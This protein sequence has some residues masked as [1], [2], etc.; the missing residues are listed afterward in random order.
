M[1]K[2]AAPI[3]FRVSGQRVSKP[4]GGSLRGGI[5]APA[6][7]LPGELKAGVRVGAR[8]A[9]GAE[10]KL[11][12]V[13][14]EDVVVLHIAGGPSLV[15]HPETARDLLL[16]QGRATRSGGVPGEVAVP[17]QLRWKGLEQ[18]AP[19]RTRGFLGDVLLSAVEV[20]TGL[21]KA[22]AA[23]WAA[24]ELGQRID[25]AVTPG[26][27]ALRP[28]A[29]GKLA[30][31]GAAV[32][33]AGKAPIL[34]LL[35][36]TFVDTLSTFGKLW[37]QH[38][39]RVRELFDH[40]GAASTRWTTRRWARARSPTRWR[41]PRSCPTAR[42]CTWPRIR[43]AG[44]WPRCWPAWPRGPSSRRTTS[45]SSPAP[46]TP[47]SAPIC[48]ASRSTSSAASRSSAWCAWPA[49]RAARCWP[50]AGWTPTCR[51]SSGRWSSAACRWRRRWWTSWPRWRAAAPTRRCCR[52]WRR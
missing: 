8:R 48:S 18:A 40:Y 45:P 35:H 27:Y 2:S 28:Q 51:C 19:T 22:P 44:W 3:V 16:G 52:G 33:A 6:L 9:G 20:F 42:G 5:G 38:P 41:W 24:R 32:P 36:G 10:Q 1:A 11:Q 49:R 21:L 7:A 4:V 31:G 37:V 34:V 29:L 17:A 25:G 13:P 43:A 50:R 39:H 14:G 46:S 26:V 47:A 12:A 23:T 15:L 30:G